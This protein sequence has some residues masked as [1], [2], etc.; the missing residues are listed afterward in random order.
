[1]RFVLDTN[2]L[3][4]AFRS[5]HGA[6]FALVSALPIAGWQLVLSV[7]VYLEYQDVL[8]RSGLLPPSFSRAD[9]TEF[10]RFL[11]SISHA[12]D[13]HFKWPAFLPDP[14][15]DMVLELAVAAGATHIVTHN[16]RHFSTAESFGVNAL[17]PAAFLR[18]AEVK[19]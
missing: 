3:V 16:I 13:I 2:I 15:D 1:M 7:P 12:Q 10:C 19:T 18:L 9:I 8:L 4:S 6:S 5:T 14:K 11:A 17:A